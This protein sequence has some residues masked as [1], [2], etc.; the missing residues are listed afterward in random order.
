MHL[1]LGPTR[2]LS[3]AA[4]EPLERV[5]SR[6]G[7]G[8]MI[9]P[10]NVCRRVL[11]RYPTWAADNG[12]FTTRK[13]GFEPERFRAMLCQRVLREH[14]GTCRFVAA[15]DVLVVRPDGAVSGD[16]RAT[17]EQF[18]KWAAEIRG[19]GLPVALVAQDGL[20]HLLDAVPWPSVDTLFLGGSTEWK[21][22]LGAYRCIARAQLRGKLTHMGRVNSYRRLALAQHWGVNSVDGTYLKYGPEVNLPRLLSWLRQLEKP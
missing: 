5:A 11:D 15:P 10:G 17:L 2:Y 6:Y 14:V 18:P 19:W 20:E 7:I 22:G 8:L 13:K 1:Q 21:L 4:N 12:A 9:Q 3:G 16:A